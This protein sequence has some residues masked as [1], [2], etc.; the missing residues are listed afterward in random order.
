MKLNEFF[1]N[2]RIL[3]EGGN[4]SSHDIYGEPTKGYIAGVEGKHE[5]EKIDAKNRTIMQP[6]VKQMLVDI[7]NTFYRNYDRYIWTPELIEKEVE[8]FI[9]GSSKWFMMLRQPNPKF[10]PKEPVSDT[11][12]KEIGVTNDDFRRVKKKVGDVD[13]QVDRRL[14]PQIEEFLHK[15]NGKNI[16]SATLLGFKKG[17]DQWLA[18]WKIHEPPINLQVDLEFSDYR[19]D[20]RGFEIPTEW[21]QVS[22]GS[23]MVDLE[24]S[25]KGVFRQWLYR[26]MAKISP[27]DKYVARLAGRGKNRKITVFG[28]DDGIEQV[29]DFE[30]PPPPV[31]DANFT[32]AVASSG[33]GGARE[34][35][36]KVRP[37]DNIPKKIKDVNVFVELDPKDSKYIQDLSQQFRLFF[38]TD[39]TDNEQRMMHS[40]VGSVELMET[41]L[42]KEQQQIAVREFIKLCFGPAGQMIDA[43]DPEA[44]F[45]TKMPAIDYL[46]DKFGMQGIR[47]GALEMAKQYESAY[48]TKKSVN[49]AE[50]WSKKYK[51]SINCSHPK[52][53]SQKAHC[54]GK[55]KHN[56]SAET[57]MV[58]PDCGMCKT[59]GNNM[60]EI[61]QRLD[62]NCWKGKHK[63][64]TKIKGGIRVNN[65]VPN[66]GLNEAEG[67]PDYRRVGIKHIYNPGS[68]VEMPPLQFIDMCQEIANS[69]GTLDGV[70]INLKVDGA[71]IRFGK[72]QS[73]Q[74]F[75][76]TSKV[77]KP[78]YASDVGSF[79]AYGVSNG[80]DPEQ[81]KRTEAYDHALDLITNSQFVKSLP[82][83][84]II[85]AEMLFNE[86]AEQTPDGMKFVNIAYDPKRLG[87]AMTL[88]PIMAKRYSTGE[89]LPNEGKI[90]DGLIKQSSP[91]IKIIGNRLQQQGINVKNIVDP[92]ARNAEQLK[93]I[94]RPRSKDS[95]EKQQAQALLAQAR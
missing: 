67:K 78:L 2:T 68:T 74:P 75:M 69:G 32:F 87:K 41:H 79:R 3:R 22:H 10:N 8:T 58:C 27:S 37:E 9:S 60:M 28:G 7:N 4:L 49:M 93:T 86:M 56:E 40:L 38:G 53:F 35:Y 64:G 1:R 89:I 34:K 54:A 72:D 94:F 26:A 95:A 52:G 92:I 11:N 65:C 43:D 48:R 47:K 6:V 16:G 66:E 83:D 73:G 77:D 36:R 13:T 59:H 55:K 88:V 80:Q 25:I 12:P 17:N 70:Q 31:H 85:Q 42:D 51:R 18:L 44:D 71:G 91:Q 23:Q 14:E 24:K 84:T 30:N 29:T 15:I 57:E 20:E 19:T 45:K 46:L 76:M 21:A 63:E 61:K 81:L 62:A 50:G 39:P 33:G 5:A 90:I 82:A